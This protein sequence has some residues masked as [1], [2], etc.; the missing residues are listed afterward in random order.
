MKMIN[1]RNLILFFLTFVASSLAHAIGSCSTSP[2]TD[3]SEC[4]AQPDIQQVTF[5]K[6]AVCTAQPGT[7]NLSTPIDLSS[8]TTVYQSSAGGTVAIQQG[9]TTV[10]SNGDFTLPPPK[11]YSYIYV[12]ISP[13]MNIQATK[14]FSRTITSRGDSSAGPVCWSITDTRFGLDTSNTGSSCGA[15]A[16]GT[17]GFNTMKI[18][19]LDGTGGLIVTSKTFPTSKGA[20]LQA[21]LLTSDGKIAT[22]SSGS[23]GTVSK[24]GAYI[25]Q[26]LTVT[27][28]TAELVINYNNLQGTSVTVNANT[29]GQYSGGPFDMF[30]EAQ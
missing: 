4:F 1:I 21:Y 22:A 15:A 3:T 26:S 24:I 16:N 20:T 17:L 28:N 9:A 29:M 7:P 11:T 23:L 12:E 2:I 18:N 8:C 6:A 10:L 27:S 19:T 14:R 25:P 13:T 30:V 5:Y